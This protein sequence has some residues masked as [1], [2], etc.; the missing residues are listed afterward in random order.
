MMSRTQL[1]EIAG[2]RVPGHEGDERDLAED[3]ISVL[4][5][6]R[7]EPREASGRW[8]AGGPPSQI[9]NR[10]ALMNLFNTATPM[11][12]GMTLPR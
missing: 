4:F 6:E 7:G 8:E 10:E 3:S 1:D 5:D 11:S 9:K 2:V 12:R